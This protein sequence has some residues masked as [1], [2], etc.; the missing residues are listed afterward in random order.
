MNTAVKERPPKASQVKR[1]LEKERDQHPTCGAHSRRAKILTKF[2][3]KMAKLARPP[4][5]ERGTLCLEGRCSIQL[6]Y[7]RNY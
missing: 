3:E 6:S 1:S 4:R 7:G 2:P 5:F